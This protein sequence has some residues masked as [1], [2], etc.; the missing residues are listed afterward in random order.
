M[1]RDEMEIISDLME[2]LKAAMGPSQDDFDERL[3][4]QKP[5][6]AS[7][8]IETSEGEFPEEEMSFEETA[9]E[10]EEDKL[11]NRLLKIRG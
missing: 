2:E 5:E 1:Q 8:E 9:P 6:A 7:I 4:R 10:S 11:K 3:G